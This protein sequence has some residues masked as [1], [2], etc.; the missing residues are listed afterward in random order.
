[1]RN[2]CAGPTRG[3]TEATDDAALVEALGAT[4]RVVPGDPR[5]LKITTPADLGTAEQSLERLSV[6]IGQGIDIHRFSDD[7]HR[8]LVLGGVVIEGARGLGGHSDADAVCHAIWPTPC[9]AQWGSATWAGTFPIP[10][11]SGRG[12]TASSC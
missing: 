11:R 6:R 7:P 10:T 4:V 12:R 2:C 9:S 5:N 3:G 1:M 8:P